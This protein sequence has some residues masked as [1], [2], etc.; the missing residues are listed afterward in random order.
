M[1][2]SQFESILKDFE[3]FFQ[4]QLQPDANDSCL[5]KLASGLKVQI[6]MNS[7]GFLIVGCRLGALQMGRFRERVI[8]ES[9]KANEINAP[10]TGIFGYSHKSQQ[11]ILFLSIDPKGVSSDK[12]STLIEPFVAKAQLW[13]DAL[14]KGE[15]PPLS[16]MASPLS[17]SFFGI[18]P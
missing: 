9:L 13:S 12:I 1:V 6:E 16:V 7:L 17:P 4:C 5:V 3:S 11:L 8:Q 10:S 15:T 14:S 2:S 18:K